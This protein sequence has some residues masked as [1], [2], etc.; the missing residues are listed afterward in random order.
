MTLFSTDSQRFKDLTANYDSRKFPLCALLT[1]A[2]RGRCATCASEVRGGW[3]SKLRAAQENHVAVLCP[4]V[5]AYWK[6]GVCLNEHGDR[7]LRTEFWPAL[8]L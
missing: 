1:G 7:T 8:T 2:S 4:E 3:V 5:A 6:V